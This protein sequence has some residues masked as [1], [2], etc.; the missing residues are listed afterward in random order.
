M[1][2]RENTVLR[3]RPALWTGVPRWGAGPANVQ[4][5]RLRWGLTCVS[6]GAWAAEMRAGPCISHL[7]LVEAPCG[8][9]ASWQETRIQG[10]YGDGSQRAHMRAPGRAASP[11]SVSDGRWGRSSAGKYG[12]FNRLSARSARRPL[13]DL[14]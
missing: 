4:N 13:T 12:T 3:T 1:L 14:V 5:P 2:D 7:A 11:V 6:R 8:G 9:Y 10:A